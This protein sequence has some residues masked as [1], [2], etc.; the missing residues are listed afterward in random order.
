VGIIAMFIIRNT[1]T[2]KSNLHRITHQILGSLNS[3]ESMVTT[4]LNYRLNV[5]NVQRLNGAN[6]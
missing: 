2:L 6:A 5:G 1:V 3:Y 4:E